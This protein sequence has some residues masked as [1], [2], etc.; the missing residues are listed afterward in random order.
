MELK[1]L[2]NLKSQIS[3]LEPVI[4]IMKLYSNTRHETRID[5]IGIITR[6]LYSVILLGEFTRINP[7]KTLGNKSQKQLIS[8]PSNSLSCCQYMIK[9]E[10]KCLSVKSCVRKRNYS[11]KKII[12]SRVFSV[13]VRKFSSPRE[14]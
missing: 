12:Y 3:E 6:M 13:K 8:L 7:K 2:L 4:R 1:K 14:K 9:I 5:S 10:R 11:R